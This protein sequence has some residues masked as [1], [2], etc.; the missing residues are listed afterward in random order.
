MY[1]SYPIAAASGLLALI[2]IIVALVLTASLV[3]S[4]IAELWAGLQPLLALS[5][6]R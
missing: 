3:G 4:F 5:S 2:V 6:S 1:R